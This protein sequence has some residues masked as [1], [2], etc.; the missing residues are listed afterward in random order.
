[1]EWD[2]FNKYIKLIRDD[3]YYG[4]I[5][6]SDF[7]KID[8]I[9]YYLIKFRFYILVYFIYIVNKWGYFY[10]KSWYNDFSSFT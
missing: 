7:K 8:K 1:M 2:T 9:L 3:A 4:C 10:E 6:L 5:D